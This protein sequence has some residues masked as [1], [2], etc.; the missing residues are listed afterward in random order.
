MLFNIYNSNNLY[1]ILGHFEVIAYAIVFDE[2][3]YY[4]VR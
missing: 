3:N 2:L 4:F 1:A